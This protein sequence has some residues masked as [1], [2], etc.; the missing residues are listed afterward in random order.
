MPTLF[1]HAIAATAGGHLYARRPMPARFWVWTLV[2][3]ALP[4]I[5]VVAFAAGIPYGAMFGHRGFTHSLVFAALTGAAVAA[6]YAAG[7]GDRY[8]PRF[9]AASRTL[10]FGLMTASHPL[11]D[12]LTRG[13]FGVALLA[14]FTDARYVLPWQPM[15]ASPIGPSFFGERGLA[16]LLAEIRWIWVPSALVT[17]TVWIARKTR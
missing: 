16:V 4:D 13:A 8:A 5:D 10:Y 17:L 3:S 9:D 1:S 15:D 14:P 7:G 6:A 2:C 11:L 12:A